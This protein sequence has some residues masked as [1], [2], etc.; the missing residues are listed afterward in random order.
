MYYIL[1]ECKDPKKTSLYF[2]ISVVK[3]L[4]FLQIIILVYFNIPIYERCSVYNN[5][6]AALN[7]AF[8]IVQ[9]IQFYDI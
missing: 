5:Q 7:I 1:D 6:I 3:S 4:I 9:I 2:L 8:Y